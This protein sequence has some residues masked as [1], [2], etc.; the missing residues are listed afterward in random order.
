MEVVQ[1]TKVRLAGLKVKINVLKEK[2]NT[3][4]GNGISDID[5]IAL[6]GLQE[7]QDELKIELEI[8]NYSN[9]ELEKHKNLLLEY[10]D[11]QPVDYYFSKIFD[12]YGMK[13]EKQD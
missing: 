6:H 13:Y 4:E 8:I 3:T 10:S 1:I 9:D 7:E 2:I 5:L 12:K 11:K